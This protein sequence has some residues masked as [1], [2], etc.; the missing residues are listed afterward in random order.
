[1]GRFFFQSPE[2]GHKLGRQPEFVDTGDLE[3]KSPHAAASPRSYFPP[4]TMRRL[5]PYTIRT[6]SPQISHYSPTYFTFR[7]ILIEVYRHEN[8]SIR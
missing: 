1:M 4:Q 6:H 8:I 3:K 2:V 7:Q 5:N